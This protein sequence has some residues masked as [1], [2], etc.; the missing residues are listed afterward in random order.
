MSAFMQKLG[1]AISNGIFISK[2]QQISLRLNLTQN[3][4]I[5]ALKRQISFTRTNTMLIELYQIYTPS[6]IKKKFLTKK[7]VAAGYMQAGH[8][9]NVSH[10]SGPHICYSKK[11]SYCWVAM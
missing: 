5:K 8:F 6:Y 3:L 10:Y 11:Q 9:G 7:Y 1:F 4:G 2:P